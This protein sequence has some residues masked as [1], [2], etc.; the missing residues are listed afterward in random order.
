MQDATTAAVRATIEPSVA[1]YLFGST[2]ALGVALTAASRSLHILASTGQKLGDLPYSDMSHQLQLVR[3]SG[4]PCVWVPAQGYELDADER[5]ARYQMD[6]RTRS[7]KTPDPADRAVSGGRSYANTYPF[8]LPIAGQPAILVR[9]DDLA[10]WNWPLY[11]GLN[12]LP[13][14]LFGFSVNVALQTDTGN[15]EVDCNQIAQVLAAIGLGDYTGDQLAAHIASDVNDLPPDFR[16]SDQHSSARV[17]LNAWDGTRRPLWA[18]DINN[19]LV[20]NGSVLVQP[21]GATEEW[22]LPRFLRFTVSRTQDSFGWPH[23]IIYEPEERASLYAVA[24][25]IAAAFNAS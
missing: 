12:D 19:N 18:R 2:G 15:C 16:L 8:W 4:L 13:V 20:R 22:R 10:Y 24:D 25:R 3:S 5:D 7:P 21:A 1:A 6:S 14:G 11:L 9:K 23:G 17:H